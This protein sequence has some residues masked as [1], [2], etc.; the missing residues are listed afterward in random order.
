LASQACKKSTGIKIGGW[1]VWGQE[2]VI[3]PN[4][5]SHQ[6]V[7]DEKLTKMTKRTPPMSCLL[8]P[9]LFKKTGCENVNEAYIKK[10]LAKFKPI[11]KSK[12]FSFMVRTGFRE[13]IKPQPT[14]PHQHRKT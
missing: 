2:Y 5:L 11:V 4:K 3:E 14:P 1:H 13:G 10:A 7:K 12:R 9:L 8:S 6:K